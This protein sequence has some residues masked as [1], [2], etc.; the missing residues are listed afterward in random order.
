MEKVE[1]YPDDHEMRWEDPVFEKLVREELARLW[2]LTDEERKAFMERP[3]TAADLAS[4]WHDLGQILQ[5]EGRATV[6]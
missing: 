6:F 1:D 2:Q 4:G 5:S 3:V